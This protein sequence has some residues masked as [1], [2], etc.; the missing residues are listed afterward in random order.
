M[1]ATVDAEKL[2]AYM[3]N[4]P[5]I[6]VPGRT[7]PVTGYFLEDVV[8][9]TQYHLDANSDSPYA[10]IPRRSKFSLM[11]ANSPLTSKQT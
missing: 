4:A 11:F 8:E 9:M 5:I 2:S 10:R 7:F 1:S 6:T 3:N